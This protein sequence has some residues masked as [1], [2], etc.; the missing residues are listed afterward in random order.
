MTVEQAVLDQCLADPAVDAIVDERGYQLRLP[1]TPTY[2]AFRVQE[3]S[4]PLLHHL[5]GYDLT[6]RARVQVDVFAEEGDDNDA[7]A[8]CVALADAIEGA[9]LPEPFTDGSPAT[10]EVTGVLRLNREVMYEPDDLRLVRI[11]LDFAVWHRA[12]N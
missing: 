10:L 4:E 1:Q 8:D 3:I 9:L 5:R 2:P 11:M 7:Y 12:V 6:K